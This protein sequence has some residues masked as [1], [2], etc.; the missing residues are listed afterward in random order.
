MKALDREK[1]E[2]FVVVCTEM[3]SEENDAVETKASDTHS[4]VLAWLM[5]GQ[6]PP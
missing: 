2:R 6:A 4:S 5:Q 3:Y 1:K